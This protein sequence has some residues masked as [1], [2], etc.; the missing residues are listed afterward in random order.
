MTLNGLRNQ[1]SDFHAAST[2]IA[3]LTSIMEQYINAEH[4]QD[5]YESLAS[6]KDDL[7]IEILF[8][9][10]LLIGPSTVF[11]VFPDYLV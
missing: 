7:S 6:L 9:R 3:H 11:R 8:Q 10:E 2:E 5:N 1:L 4:K